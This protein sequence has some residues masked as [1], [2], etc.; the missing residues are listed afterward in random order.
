MEKEIQKEEIDSLIKQVNLETKAASLPESLDTMLSV[1]FFGVDLFGGEWQ[2]AAFARGLYRGH[3]II[4]LD[5]PTSAIDPIEE[6][7]IY[8]HSMTMIKGKT[9]FILTHRIGSARIA[10][11][12]VVMHKGKIVEMGTHDSLMNKNGHYAE[13]F[14]KQAAWYQE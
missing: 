9:A 6:H 11:R 13:M 5:E 4:V 10:D 2:R 12:I 7:R 8:N 1:E 14:H 3:D